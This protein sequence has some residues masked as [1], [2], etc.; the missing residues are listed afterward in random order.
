MLYPW[1]YAAASLIVMEAG[2]FIS[3]AEGGMITLDQPCFILAAGRQ[4]WKEALYPWDYA[5]ASLIVMEAGGFISTAEGGMITLD[6]PCFILAAGRQCWKEASQ[7][8]SE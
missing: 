4:C 7:L 6:Q 1:D 3:T 8:L 2:G 5:A